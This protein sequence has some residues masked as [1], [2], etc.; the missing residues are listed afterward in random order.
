MYLRQTSS[1]SLPNVHGSCRPRYNRLWF[2]IGPQFSADV[3]GALAP[4]MPNLAAK[5]A[6][7]YGHLNGY[8]EGVD[9]AF[10]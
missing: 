6:R 8:A 2:S 4:G 3:Y 9:G 1:T 5:M 7:E 10:F